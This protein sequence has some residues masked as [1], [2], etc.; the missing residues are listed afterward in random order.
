MKSYGGTLIRQNY[1]L[2][3]RGREECDG[4]LAMTSVTPLI[5]RVDSADQDG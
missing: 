2:V 3:R 1:D 4:D 5:T